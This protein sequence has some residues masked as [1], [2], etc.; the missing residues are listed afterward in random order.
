MDTPATG[1]GQETFSPITVHMQEVIGV[2]FLGL[3]A[4]ALL[5]TH[6]RDLGRI[7]A[8]MAQQAAG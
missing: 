8:L 7:R 1:R 6:L 2:V 3:L 4:L 5:I